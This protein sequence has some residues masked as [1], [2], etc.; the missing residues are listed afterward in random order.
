MSHAPLFCHSSNCCPAHTCT[1]THH[2]HLHA[3]PPP[4]R[5]GC[6]DEHAPEGSQAAFLHMNF[7]PHY[8]YLL[9]S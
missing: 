6:G 4:C 9:G 1:S 8:M 5:C 2:M 7:H 3:P